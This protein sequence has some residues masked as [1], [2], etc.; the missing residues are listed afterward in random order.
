ML[1]D[2]IFLEGRLRHSPPPLG[3]LFYKSLDD[4]QFIFLN[5]GV[6]T[7]IQQQRLSTS[8]PVLQQQY[9]YTSQQQHQQQ[10]PT[11]AGSRQQQTIQQ[12][13]IS[14]PQQQQASNSIYNT[15]LGPVLASMKTTTA[16]QQ[17]RGSALYPKDG[18]H[19]FINSNTNSTNAASYAQYIS[20]T[21]TKVLF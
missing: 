10:T 15:S 4:L 14:P 19:Q 5:T 8:A 21:P 13:L 18:L 11:G 6:S 16:Q 12:Q 3:T 7:P 2:L 9:I 1:L 17:P 20:T